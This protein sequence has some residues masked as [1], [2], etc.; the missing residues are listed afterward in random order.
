MA[1][2][3]QNPPLVEVAVSLQFER[4]SGL[5]GAHLGAFWYTQR[6]K[7]P[8]A[9]TAPPI[10]SVDPDLFGSPGPLLVPS[11]RIA[12][13]NEPEQRV[14]MTSE[15]EQWMVQIQENRIVINW[16]KHDGSYPR[17]EAARDRLLATWDC[18]VRFVQAELKKSCE[19]R[20]WEIT[21]VNRVPEGILWQ[22]PSDWPKVFSGLWGG[23]FGFDPTSS[24]IAHQGSWLLEHPAQNPVARLFVEPK[25]VKAAEGQRSLLV[26]LT[27]KGSVT[28]PE[29]GPSLE[30]GHELIVSTF[31][32]ISSDTAKREWGKQ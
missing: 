20:L 23:E 10:P 31:D 15:D 1:V 24:L 7:Y 17:Y 5:N 16:R 6:D 27:A 18:W 8:H 13:L 19:P 25:M 2:T 29:I 14:Q 21:Y 26:N 32:R 3:Y 22:S 28:S 11:I 12:L 4:P 30:I 9:K